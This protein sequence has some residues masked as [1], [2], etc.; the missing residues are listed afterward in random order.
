[1]GGGAIF[2]AWPPLYAVSF[3]GFYL[4]MFVVLAA[5]HRAPGGL[6]VPLQA[7]QRPLA[8]GW[9]WAL[10]GRRVP[11]LLFGVAVGNVLQGVPFHLTDDLHADLRRGLTSSSS[12]CCDPFALLAGVVSLRCC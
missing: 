12:A 8:A 1:L 10:F 6:Q 4:A 5:L 7:R 3:S 9:D 11:A 2:A